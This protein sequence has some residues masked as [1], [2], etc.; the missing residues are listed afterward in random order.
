MT[1]LLCDMCMAV[2]MS[3]GNMQDGIAKFLKAFCGQM[4][5]ANHRH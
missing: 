5:H 2:K 3:Q 4:A 1:T